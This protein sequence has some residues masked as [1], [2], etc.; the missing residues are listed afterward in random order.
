MHPVTGLAAEQATLHYLDEARLVHDDLRRLLTQISGFALMLMT[1]PGRQVL[2]E[3]PIRGAVAAWAQA[4]EAVRALTVPLV[5]AHHYHHLC[6]ACAA[7]AQ[8]CT[9]ALACAALGAGDRDRD[10]LVESLNSAVG[11]LRGVSRLMPGFEPVNFGQA[12]C[13]VHVTLRPDLQPPAL[14]RT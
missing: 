14:G 13:A 4:D 11:H 1:S 10:A 7:V 5:A 12:C 3:A 2:P 8:S 9:A 6:S